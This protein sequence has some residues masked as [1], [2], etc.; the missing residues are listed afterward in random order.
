MQGH[1]STGDVLIFPGVHGHALPRRSA[2]STQ[3]AF[4]QQVPPRRS[5]A[6]CSTCSMPRLPSWIG[7]THAHWPASMARS[8]FK[9]VCFSYEPGPSVLHEVSFSVARGSSVALVGPTGAGKSLSGQPAAAVLRPDDRRGAAGR[10]RSARSS[11][12]VAAWPG[13][14]R[15]P[16]R[17]ARRRHDSRQ[18]RLWASRRG[19]ERCSRGGTARTS[20]R[21]HRRAAG[22]VRHDRRRARR[23][24]LGGQKQRLAIARAFLKD[25]PI[26]VLDEPTS[27][28]DAHT[29]AAL[30]QSLERLMKGR[31]TFIIA[32]RLSTAHLASRI[33]VVDKGR[34]LEQGTHEELLNR[35]SYPRPLSQPGA[36]G[37]IGIPARTPNGCGRLVRCHFPGRDVT[38]PT[39]RNNIDFMRVALSAVP[40]NE[41]RAAA[42]ASDSG[43]CD[44]IVYSPPGT[45]LRCERRLMKDHE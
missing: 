40:K 34:I 26:L 25:A 18:H 14:R 2:L 28:L 12:S 1:L 33:L 44:L 43:S 7:R 30:L 39:R 41:S 37:A 27:A 8:A 16:G 36:R 10:Y 42:G 5:S 29:E 4:G 38:P 3:G 22:R 13:E 9:N 15:A 24:N 23:Q 19:D 31:T 6:G 21:V 17:P 32:H 11:G 20:G 35:D 45:V